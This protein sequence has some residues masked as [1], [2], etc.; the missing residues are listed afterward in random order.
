MCFFS[1]FEPPLKYLFF[2][3]ND[4]SQQKY[5]HLAKFYQ[6]LFHNEKKNDIDIFMVIFDFFTVKAI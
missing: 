1:N 4:Q 5:L 3:K 2:G 6:N